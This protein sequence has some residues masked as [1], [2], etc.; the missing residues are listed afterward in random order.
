[1]ACARIESV[2]RYPALD[3]LRPLIE[4]VA[5]EGIFEADRMLRRAALLLKLVNRYGDI[6]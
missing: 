2:E 1:M 3:R 4:S 6:D 5:A